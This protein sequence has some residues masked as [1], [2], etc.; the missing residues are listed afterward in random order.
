MLGASQQ[1][2]FIVRLQ[3][4]HQYSYTKKTLVRSIAQGRG[5]FG[6]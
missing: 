1:K 4:Y 2:A 6:H 3:Q 5:L